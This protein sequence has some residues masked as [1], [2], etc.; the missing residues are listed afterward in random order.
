[1]DVKTE[2]KDLIFKTKDGRA[3]RVNDIILAVAT[4]MSQ[5]NYVQPICFFLDMAFR[6]D[7]ELLVNAYNHFFVDHPS[8]L[9]ES[10]PF[11][12]KSTEDDENEDD[13]KWQQKYGEGI[14]V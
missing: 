8:N 10:V 2:K 13:Y 7:H 1:M 11:L 9:T 12:S 3:Y 4:T 5:P 14:E 6:E